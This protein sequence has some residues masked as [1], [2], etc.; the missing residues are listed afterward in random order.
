MISEILLVLPARMWTTGLRRHSLRQ[1]HPLPSEKRDVM[2]IVSLNLLSLRFRARKRK[3]TLYQ[4]SKCSHPPRRQTPHIAHGTQSH[5]LGTRSRVGRRILLDPLPET[6]QRCSRKFLHGNLIA[7][8]RY[9]RMARQHPPDGQSFV[10][11]FPRPKVSG[12]FPRWTARSTE[13]DRVS[14]ETYSGEPC[15]PAQLHRQRVL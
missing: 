9:P 12:S 7:R 5:R 4:H 2:R 15:H 8:L 14:Q 6:C 3:E 11:C 10:V 1:E 13:M